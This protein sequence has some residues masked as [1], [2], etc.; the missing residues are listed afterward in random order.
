MRESRVYRAVIT[1]EELAELSQALSKYIRYMIS[2]DT[3]RKDRIEIQE[4]IMEEIAD[5]EICLN[6]FKKLLCIDES[7]L[8]IIKQYKEKRLNHV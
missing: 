1:I 8:D 2:D 3:L 4:M 5:V 6:K 7:D